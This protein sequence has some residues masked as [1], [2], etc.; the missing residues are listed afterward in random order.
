MYAVGDYVVKVN[1]G[2]CKVEDITRLTIPGADRN[3]LY[4]LLIPLEDAGAK[5]YIPVE[6]NVEQNLRPVITKEQAWELINRIGE[7]DAASITDEKQRESSYKEALHSCEPERVVSVL[8]SIY[9][10]KQERDAQGK[11]ITAVDDRYF[12]LAEDVLH[13]ELAFAIGRDKQEMREV[14]SAKMNSLNV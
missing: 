3:R 11:K 10:R 1:K 12:K 13:S 6:G 14:I 7:I 2:V 8:K 5:L 9:Q 4:Y